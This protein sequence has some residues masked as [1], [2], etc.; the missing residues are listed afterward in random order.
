MNKLPEI[1]KEVFIRKSVYGHTGLTGVVS[2]H[3][4]EGMIGLTVKDAAR[5]KVTIPEL[6]VD[7]GWCYFVTEVEQ[8]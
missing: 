1:G 3:Y 8:L 5:P 2:E 7:E 6:G 4:D